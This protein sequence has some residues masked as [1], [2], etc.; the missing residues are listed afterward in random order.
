MFV[1]HFTN[2]VKLILYDL[3]LCIFI[4]VYKKKEIK[5][6]SSIYV[7]N[8]LINNPNEKIKKIKKK[9]E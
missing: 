8:F 2:E 4:S 5:S 6:I 3:K 9:I 7:N 1:K